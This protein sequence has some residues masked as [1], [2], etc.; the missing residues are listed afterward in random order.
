MIITLA[1]KTILAALIIYLVQKEHFGLAVT[2]VCI[3]T[4]KEFSEYDVINTVQ[5]IGKD[6][7]YAQW[8]KDLPPENV[9]LSPLSV[10]VILTLLILGT[11]GTSNLKIKQALNY[12]NDL[13]EMF[14]S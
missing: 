11:N 14:R 4:D 3:D 1:F 10:A 9:I 6:I 5:E 2:Q 7:S 8:D 13:Q 12:P